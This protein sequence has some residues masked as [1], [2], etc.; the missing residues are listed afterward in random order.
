MKR[1]IDKKSKDKIIDEI[2]SYLDRYHPELQ[3]A[4]VF[5]SFISD[6]SFSDIDIGLLTSSP[7]SDRLTYE[8][9]LEIGIEMHIKLPVDIR[10]LNKA[11]LSFCYS[12][13]RNKKVI[14]DRDA[15]F[16]AE[17]ESIVLRQYF[18]FFP[19]HKRYLSEVLNAPI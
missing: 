2:A 9:N 1:S 14:L 3:T 19:F 17:F 11:P 6:E 5:G 15:N 12:V 4:Y 16:R 18:D 7:I 8:L 13:I 10:V